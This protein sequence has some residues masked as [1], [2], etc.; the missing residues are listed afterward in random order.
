MFVE[1]IMGSVIY[2]S[3]FFIESTDNKW[4]NVDAWQMGVVSDNELVNQP[5]LMLNVNIDQGSIRVLPKI[6]S[7]YLTRSRYSHVGILS[8]EKSH[9]WSGCAE[10]SSLDHGKPMKLI[11]S[12]NSPRV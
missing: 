6:I 8:L 10:P 7:Y 5:Y 9:S 12:G 1:W 3:C 2:Y 4:I 11:Y